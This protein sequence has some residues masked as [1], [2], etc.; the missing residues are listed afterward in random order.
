M[1]KLNR[2]NNRKS[3]RYARDESALQGI[4]RG[5]GSAAHGIGSGVGG[6][7]S[8]VGSAVRG[9]GHAIGGAFRAEDR[10]TRC[11]RLHR[12]LDYVLESLENRRGHDSLWRELNPVP[13]GSEDPK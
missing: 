9:I 5:V 8:G 1:S 3:F 10:S 6:I 11:A 7:A 4:S 2:P 12:T 13:E